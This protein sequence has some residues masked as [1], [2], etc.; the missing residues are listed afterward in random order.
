MINKKPGRPPDS[1]LIDACWR[2]NA[3]RLYFGS[4]VEAIYGDDWDDIPYESNC[5]PVYSE[6]VTCVMDVLIPFS[7]TITDTADDMCYGNSKYCRNDFKSGEI[8]LFR[9]IDYSINNNDDME[10]HMGDKREAV[11]NKLKLITSL[12]RYTMKDK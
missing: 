6:Y 4:S 1:Y 3:L 9:I 12:R 7:H 8:P 5:G 2:G 10:F 11:V